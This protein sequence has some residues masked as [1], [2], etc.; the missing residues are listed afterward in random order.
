MPL[1]IRES[2][3]LWVVLVTAFSAYVSEEKLGLFSIASQCIFGNHSEKLDGVIV[4]ATFREAYF[5]T[6]DTYDIR[7]NYWIADSPLRGRV[8]G[9]ELRHV[10]VND[11]LNEFTVGKN[12]KIYID[13]AKPRYS[14]LDPS[15]ELG[16]E[17]YLRLVFNLIL[18][19][20]LTFAIVRM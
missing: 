13:P 4:Q 11:R 9:C 19:P 2:A 14:V 10:D 12:V 15:K 16:W 6:A 20:L 5:P 18:L 17:I 1:Y 7:Y 3:A 8:V